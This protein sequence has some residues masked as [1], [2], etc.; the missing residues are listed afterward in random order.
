MA[1]II[2]VPAAIDIKHSFST[3]ITLDSP[4]LYIVAYYLPVNRARSSHR[5]IGLSQSMNGGEKWKDGRC[6][7][8]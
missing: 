8:A 6:A 2:A 1:V 3:L 7:W 5:I 4:F